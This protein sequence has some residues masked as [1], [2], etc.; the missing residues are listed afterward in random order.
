M[1]AGGLVLSVRQAEHEEVLGRGAAGARVEVAQQVHVHRVLAAVL[2][3]S[4][5]H[6]GHAHLPRQTDPGDQEGNTGL[7]MIWLITL[8]VAYYTTINFPPD[9]KSNLYKCCFYDL[10]TRIH[11]LM[12]QIVKSLRTD[13]KGEPMRRRSIYVFMKTQN[14]IIEQSLKLIRMYLCIIDNIYSF[15]LCK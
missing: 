14:M 5:G 9:Q 6:P 1:L 8:K 12:D 15:Q 13:L 11:P 3:G 7:Q 2:S 10:V 4:E